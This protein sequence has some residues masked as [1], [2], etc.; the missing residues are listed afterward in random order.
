MG[1]YLVAVALDK[2]QTFL[3]YCIDSSLQEQQTEEDTLKSVMEA[4]NEI[5][6]IFP[7]MVKEIL[8]FKGEPL[9]TISGKI[10]FIIEGIEEEE[11]IKKLK[12]LY[13]TYYYT[14]QGKVKIKYCY[15]STSEIDKNTVK[16]I[17]KYSKK[18][19]SQDTTNKV[20]ED[21]Q[22]ILFKLPD[23]RK[24]EE[25][26]EKYKTGKDKIMEEYNK[27]FI[28]TNS[29]KLVR[30]LD[31]LV[32]K[33]QKNTGETGKIA[34]IKADINNMGLVMEELCDSCYL[35]ISQALN[36]KIT[37]D[38]LKNSL[39]TEQIKICPFYAAGDD[40]FFATSINY[41]FKSVQV[42]KRI[43]K[44]LNDE[45]ENEGCKKVQLSISIGIEI[46][47][48]DL[49]L[50]YY[51]DSVEHQLKKAKDAAKETEKK[52]QASICI[53]DVVFFSYAEDQG[54][55]AEKKIKT[56]DSKMTDSSWRKFGDQVFMLK[57]IGNM[58]QY[59]KG[60]EKIA[61]RTF[62]FNLLESIENPEV[63]KDDIKY[64]T[65][66]LHHLTPEYLTY[67]CVNKEKCLMDLIAKTVLVNLLREGKTINLSEEK[68]KQFEAKI[69]LFLLFTDKRYGNSE[70]NSE[71]EYHDVKG[72]YNRKKQTGK[73]DFKK[74]KSNLLNIPLEYL[75]KVWMEAGNKD[76][77]DFN[78]IFI[79]RKTERKIEKKRE[80]GIEKETKYE[81]SYFV[82]L[83]IG[84]SAI[85]RMKNIYENKDDGK[86]FNKISAILDNFSIKE[87]GEE[88]QNEQ[89]E[90]K[91]H[92]YKNFET[93]KFNLLVN[94]H[95][96]NSDFFDTLLVLYQFD[97]YRKIISLMINNEENLN[98]SKKNK[99]IEN[100]GYNVN[101]KGD[102]KNGK[103]RRNTTQNNN[104]K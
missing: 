27:S 30:G 39:E 38:N 71:K 67:P 4:S 60:L 43:L 55:K 5:R 47:N 2:V 29:G 50:R 56:T 86:K 90:K 82:K 92:Y 14:Y 6:I 87:E 78:R 83:R 28:W 35:K 32:N 102:M 62:L 72:E 74:V 11:V 23:R 85:Y 63:K 8:G 93:G 65:A 3:Y 7:E 73:Y 100:K 46:N 77:K 37:I 99:R 70:A 75:Y 31:D 48:S 79:E 34:F 21:N 96:L 13:E 20:I 17:K 58:K 103:N 22:D 88:G 36:E 76:R 54:T 101:K 12:Q 98:K 15:T 24:C 41:I 42:L 16:S 57:A 68:K 89:K 45:L 53:N 61:S 44:E 26:K 84:V 66:V 64:L 52:I 80:N 40:I 18:L 49:P 33:E 69:R 91:R 10:I 51:Y 104:K 59:D 25:V 19:K 1:D 97:Y 94:K 9:L 81:I 95:Y